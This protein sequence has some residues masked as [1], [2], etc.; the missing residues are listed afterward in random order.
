MASDPPRYVLL[1]NPDTI[2]RPGALRELFA[3]MEDR[4]DVGIAGSRL[5]GPDGTPQRSAFR[6]PSILGELEGGVRL[7]LLSRLL[8]RWVVAPEVPEVPGATDWVSGACMIVRGA[9]F[10]EIG[11][12]DEGYFMYYEEVDFC[13]RARRAS[14]PCWYVPMARVVH[15]GGR[16]SGVDDRRAARGRRPSYWFHARRRYF[17][18][19]HGRFSM[20]LADLAWSLGYATYRLRRPVQRKPDTDPERLLWDFIRFNFLLAKR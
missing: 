20:A 7:G 18:N 10:E 5:E 17:L 11:L 9:V 3:F 8:S 1:L 16:S 15:L 14:W 6:F 12:M 19:H 4:P 13:R 2:V